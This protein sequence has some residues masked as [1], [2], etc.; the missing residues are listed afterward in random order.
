MSNA[1]IYAYPSRV[2]TWQRTWPPSC[3]TARPAASAGSCAQ[4][5]RRLHSFLTPADS[6][7]SCT[8]VH[9]CVRCV[10][11]LRA[12][13]CP[14]R[15]CVACVCV[16]ARARACSV[17]ERPSCMALASSALHMVSDARRPRFFDCLPILFVSS[18]AVAEVYIT[19]QAPLPV[20]VHHYEDITP[21]LHVMQTAFASIAWIH[22]MDHSM[23]WGLSGEL[24]RLVARSQHRFISA[25]MPRSS[26]TLHRCHRRRI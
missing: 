13:V 22:S 4:S 1:C 9:A 14:L 16:C 15:A 3:H 26:R 8:C 5:R 11:A 17:A 24:D 19:Q 2:Y 25:M 12:C 7:P 18:F 10:R 6:P 23:A 21:K 20:L